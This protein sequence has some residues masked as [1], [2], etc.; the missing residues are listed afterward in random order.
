LILDTNA[1]PAYLDSTPEA[2][3]IVSEARDL[4]IPAIVAGEFV[5]GVTQS[6]HREAYERALERM[7]DRCTVLDLEIN[8]AR[9]Y[10]AIRSELKVA[11]EDVAGAVAEADSPAPSLGSVLR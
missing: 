8:T 2:V 5:F 4:A 6:R 9:Q 7:R 11:C 3:E 1:L 10:A